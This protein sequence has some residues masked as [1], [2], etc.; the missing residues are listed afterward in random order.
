M[1][2]ERHF[3]RSLRCLERHMRTP[4]AG[5]VTGSG[6]TVLGVRLILPP[7]LPGRRVGLKDLD[8]GRP[9]W[10]NT[11]MAFWHWKVNYIPRLISR[12]GCE[13]HGLM[14]AIGEHHG[15]GWIPAL[16][17]YEPA[18]GTHA[19][20]CVGRPRARAGVGWESTGGGRSDSGGRA[21]YRCRSESVL[22]ELLPAAPDPG[23]T[24]GV[25]MHCGVRHAAS[26]KSRNAGPP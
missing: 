6:T 11:C 7:R 14:P 1:S 26:K 25:R 4:G 19:A 17:A 20:P 15:V 5:G 22:V 10:Q 9:L 23:G 8:A 21:C 18:E 12:C 24:C 3:V 16:V 13:C 2:V